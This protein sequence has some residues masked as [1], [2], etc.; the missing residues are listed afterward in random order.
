MRVD[1]ST[2]LGHGLSVLN[3][4]PCELYVEKKRKKEKREKNRVH[5]KSILC[6]RSGTR[7]EINSLL[8]GPWAWMRK[9]QSLTYRQ[10]NQVRESFK[11]TYTSWNEGIKGIFVGFDRPFYVLSANHQDYMRFGTFWWQPFP[12]ENTLEYATSVI[13]SPSLMTVLTKFAFHD[14]LRD[15]HPLTQAPYQWCYDAVR[16]YACW[17][18]V[19]VSKFLT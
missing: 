19:Y 6:S 11:L 5:Q 10:D 9:K 16:C 15:L 12:T 7:K 1:W 3:C 2:M 14:I 13:S 17:F 4:G 18:S 8:D